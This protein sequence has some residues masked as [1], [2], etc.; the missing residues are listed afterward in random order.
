M[1]EE[2]GNSSEPRTVAASEGMAATGVG[3]GKQERLPR[4]SELS[5]K[6]E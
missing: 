2:K 4:G 6:E 3:E 1:W 5:L